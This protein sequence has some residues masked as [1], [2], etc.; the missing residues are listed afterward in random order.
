MQIHYTTILESRF[1][2]PYIGTLVAGRYC[3]G[4]CRGCFNQHLKSAPVSTI[5]ADHLL[6]KIQDDP[7]SEGI[8][9]GGLEWLDG[10][11]DEA[12]YLLSMALARGM[13]A[14]LYTRL[15]ADEIQKWYPKLMELSGLY[16]K[17]GPYLVAKHTETLR[18]FDVPL[19]SENQYI[20]QIK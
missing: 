19:A 16:I 6:D 14:M 20:V 12:Y 9:L 3:N 2:A 17:C 7:F 8:I 1:D 11:Y 5:D 4:T 18:M 15:Y 10:Q 13:K